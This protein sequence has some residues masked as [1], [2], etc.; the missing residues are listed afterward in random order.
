M[1]EWGRYPRTG[2]RK[3][4]SSLGEG[5]EEGSGTYWLVSF[6][7]LPGEMMKQITLEA[8]SKHTKDRGWLG[9]ASKDLQR[10]NCA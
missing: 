6:P 9:V 5:M 3:W 8:I 4:H 7:S 10:G 2:R 1:G